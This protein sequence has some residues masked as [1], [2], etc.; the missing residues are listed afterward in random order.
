[1]GFA[2]EYWRTDRGRFGSGVE[3]KVFILGA[4]I[5][6][7]PNKFAGVEMTTRDKRSRKRIAFDHQIESAVV[8]V[9]GTW[10][11]KG[12]VEDISET[13]AKFSA[14]EKTDRRIRKDEFFLVLGGDGKVN[15]RCRALWQKGSSFGLQFLLERRAGRF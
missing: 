6:E 13:G 5:F 14:T 3:H 11:I 10:S 9:D 12:R 15:R 1:L 8:A 4:L 7:R 2:V